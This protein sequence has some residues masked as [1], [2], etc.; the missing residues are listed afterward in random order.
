[1]KKLCL[2][3][4]TWGSVV[5]S[6]GI[7]QRQCLMGIYPDLWLVHATV[8]CTD[9]KQEARE[10]ETSAFLR[11]FLL[12]S[13]HKLICEG[14]ERALLRMHCSILTLCMYLWYPL[15]GEGCVSHLLFHLTDQ[16]QCYTC[17]G[18]SVFLLDKVNSQKKKF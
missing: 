1:M 15:H 16:N 14:L 5:C 7:V 18:F 3:E 9:E 2:F 6:L 10:W 8:Q 13:K 4:L 12:L 11:S 17:A